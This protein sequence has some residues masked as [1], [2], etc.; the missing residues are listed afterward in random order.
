MRDIAIGL[1]K[2][3]GEAPVVL[4]V[5]INVHDDPEDVA[6]SIR[7]SIDVPIEKQASWSDNFHAIREWRSVLESVGILIFQVP[8][9][10][11][12]E[13]RGFSISL[14]PLP[15]IGINIKNSPAGR[16]FTLFHELTHILLRESVL[17]LGGRS[18]YNME[19]GF[20]IEQ[21]CN[22][23]AA[24][25][26][27]PI[28]DLRSQTKNLGKQK[29]DDWSSQETRI[30]TNRYHVSG[31]VIIRRLQTLQLISNNSYEELVQEYELIYS[32]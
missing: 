21:F 25:T 23:V 22:N 3:L 12:E 32:F 31:A 7:R 30:L 20:E 19:G 10:S 14:L 15:I 28:K 27:I 5:G 17:D 16:I 6:G 11:I 2:E 1:Y 26:L 9:I 24:A 13:T 4:N 29:H 18:W 8:G